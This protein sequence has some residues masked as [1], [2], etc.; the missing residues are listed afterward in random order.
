MTKMTVSGTPECCSRCVYMYHSAGHMLPTFPSLFTALCKSFVLSDSS[1]TAS[2]LDNRWDSSCTMFVPF[3][4]LESCSC[5]AVTSC[6][7]ASR[8]SVVLAAQ[9]LCFLHTRSA[10]FKAASM[11]S[12]DIFATRYIPERSKIVTGRLAK[13]TTNRLQ[14]IADQYAAFDALIGFTM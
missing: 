2:G 4:L 6:S 13:E 7:R 10:S 14:L 1:F 11:F 9:I 8:H 3:T 5:A 12:T